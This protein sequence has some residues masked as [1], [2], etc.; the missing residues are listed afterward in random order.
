M[1]YISTRKKAP[2]L[3]FSDV[4]LQGLASDG[5]LYI[6]GYLPKFSPKEIANFAK[7]SYQELAFKVISPFVAG[8]IENSE[9]K[10][11]IDK[12]YASFSHQAIAPTKQLSS[13]QFLLELFH[14]PTL[15]FKD[16]ALQ[17]LG[18]LFEYILNKRNEEVVII[19]ATSGDTGSAAID[20][21]KHCKH[22]KI[23]ILHPYERVSDVQRRQMTTILADNVTNIALKGDFDDCQSFVKKMFIS[24]DFLKGKRMVA[25]NSINWARIVAQIVYY[26]YCGARMNLQNGVSFSVPTGNFGD[27]YAGY[28]AKQMGLPVKKLIV[29]TNKNDILTRFFNENDYSRGTLI[30]TLSPSMNIQVSS[31][32]ERYLFDLHHGDKR[33]IKHSEVYDIMKNFEEKGG[34]KISHERLEVA[35]K[36]F[37]SYSVDDDET[38]SLIADLFHKTGEVLDPHTA[39]GVGAA[40]KYEQH[41]DY[42]GEQIVTLATAHPAKFPES[43][44]KAGLKEPALPESLADLFDKD[45]KMEILDKDLDVVK[46]FIADKI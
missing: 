38:C 21:C 15:A 42:S 1:K 46:K 6:P 43:I 27:V 19:G 34:I 10:S 2:D 23:F 36:S 40:L 33:D 24:Q 45:E 16:F 9:L 8:E 5:G 41:K 32:F 31:N 29:A 4:I 13:N 11:I 39:I 12:S 3:N 44:H 30:E 37:A 17:L 28:L 35:R 7:L 14:G 25:V 18:N 22:A 20:G 26:F